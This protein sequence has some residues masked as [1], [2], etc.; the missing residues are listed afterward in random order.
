MGRRD[1]IALILILA[2]A[3]CLRFQNLGARSLWYNEADSSCFLDLSAPEILRRSAEDHAV[4]PPLY[5]LALKGWAALFGDGEAALRSLAAIAG[6]AAVA[7]TATALRELRSLDER[8]GDGRPTARDPAPALAAALLAL[9]P[10]QVHLA[11]QVRG[12]SLAAALLAWA[13]LALARA[14]RG[15]GPRSWVAAAALALAAAYVH[16]VAALSAAALAAFAAAALAA[17][18]RESPRAARG[19][20]AALAILVLGYVLPYAGTLCR[21]VRTVLD[22]FHDPITPAGALAQASLAFGATH[23][24]AAPAP[25]DLASWA[26][27]L[28]AA[29]LL[30]LGIKGGWRGR[31]LAATGLLPV[32]A[33]AAFSIRSD[34][35]VV[36]ARYLM[37]AQASWLGGLAAAA[38]AIPQAAPRRV[39]AAWLVAAS[40]LALAAAWDDL[41]PGARP[42]MRQAV[43]AI[44]EL[45]GADEPVVSNSP[46]AFCGLQHYARGRAEARMLVDV[47]GR[48]AQRRGSERLREEQLVTVADLEAS[49]TPGLWLV[50]GKSNTPGDL[51]P[52]PAGQSWERV[53]IWFFEQDYYLEGPVVVEH[54]RRRRAPGQPRRALA[55]DISTRREAS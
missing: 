47:P 34:R 4:H 54:Y 50:T 30:A 31:F 48:E 55:P 21:H 13:A 5:F 52:F 14:L 45:R 37:F 40:A 1:T 39:A 23:Q 9:S 17:R 19:A 24:T 53:G 16:H 22:D 28:P 44:L 18:R 8:P 36:M 12:Y 35:S 38:A 27:L 46:Y 26:P 33:L 51:T 10:L 41:G 15:A 43:R 2:L 29:A 11:R 7:G 25:G 20:A 32:L 6:V 42:G 3:A 49:E